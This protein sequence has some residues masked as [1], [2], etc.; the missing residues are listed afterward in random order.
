MLLRNLLICSFLASQSTS[1]A[2]T[3]ITN[4]STTESITPNTKPN[5]TITSLITFKIRLDLK[6]SED[7][8]NRTSE[9]Y[10]G[11]ENRVIDELT[12]TIID[13]YQ[14]KYNIS[15]SEHH[16]NIQILF[17]SSG[18]TIIGT[19]VLTMFDEV[20]V[21]NLRDSTGIPNIIVDESTIYLAQ[22]LTDS[23][24]REIGTENNTFINETVLDSEVFEDGVT[25]S[26]TNSVE[27]SVVEGFTEGTTQKE[28]LITQTLEKTVQY[29]ETT[30]LVE[31]T[32]RN[33]I[34]TP[35]N[36]EF[37]TS[38]SDFF[39][40][41]P[42]E[43]VTTAPGNLKTTGLKTAYSD[44]ENSTTTFTNDRPFVTTEDR[45]TE[46]TKSMPPS[47]PITYS[48]LVMTTESESVTTT[49][50]SENTS[51]MADDE[52]TSSKGSIEP[53]L[54][55]VITKTGNGEVATANPE[56]F[57]PEIENSDGTTNV[58][59]TTGI[60][61]QELTSVEVDTTHEVDLSTEIVETMQEFVTKSQVETAK[62]I[63]LTTM[64]NTETE[65]LTTA[66]TE[67]STRIEATT[68]AANTSQPK[69]HTTREAITPEGS[70]DVEDTTV[71][72]VTSETP[73]SES[74][75]SEPITWDSA[76]HDS[77]TSNPVTSDSNHETTN[78][79][80]PE[81]QQT[82][83]LPTTTHH[84]SNTALTLNGTCPSP[85]N[86]LNNPCPPGGVCSQL[87]ENSY[88]CNCEEHHI[89]VLHSNSSLSHC[90][91]A[92]QVDCT[93]TEM[94][95]QLYE[96][97]FLARDMNLLDIEFDGE[98]CAAKRDIQEKIINGLNVW[99]YNFGLDT[100]EI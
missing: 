98:D 66:E 46:K 97:Y 12:Q 61:K 48:N 24:L 41:V 64:G 99:E 47:D 20:M 43:D 81:N 56:T 50:M 13:N 74:F 57:N 83:K 69:S 86:N 70:I 44:F 76:T 18:S 62:E 89:G 22:N 77:A 36:N 39:D 1:A 72:E 28:E 63:R 93:S 51:S 88:R 34:E 17:V 33:L 4:R 16:I 52:T 10:K 23:I 29:D 67:V 7:F 38:R 87:D 3:T 60:I 84:T 91:K 42:T 92:Y 55:T 27:T 78:P 54:T 71:V 82:S 32:S 6:F 49:K 9:I 25:I 2:E 37:G 94:V 30:K 96:G 68:G 5:T 15:L 53:A 100:T 35:G 14:S 8:K 80:T 65:S 11:L 19:R 75:T 40:V 58:Y 95:L 21:N 90:V 85:E 79:E 26:T 45:V 73:I 31:V 59:E